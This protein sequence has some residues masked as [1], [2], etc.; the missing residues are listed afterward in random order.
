MKYATGHWKPIIRLREHLSPTTL[1]A[2]RLL[3]NF[4]VVTSLHDGMNLVAKEYV[5]SRFDGDG[6]LILSSF[7]GA[8]RE[9]TDAVLVNPYAPDHLAEAIKTAIE[10]PQAERQKRMRKMRAIV[11]ENNIYKWAADMISSLVKFELGES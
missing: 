3:S 1:M 4:F 10:M 2:L 5:A 11:R 6:V 9:L 8:A 7:T